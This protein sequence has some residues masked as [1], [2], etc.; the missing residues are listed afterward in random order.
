MLLVGFGVGFNSDY[1]AIGVRFD[2]VWGGVAM[3]GSG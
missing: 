3:F 2:R 1:H